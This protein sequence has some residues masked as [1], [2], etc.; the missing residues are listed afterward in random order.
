MDVLAVAAMPPFN[1][2]TDVRPAKPHAPLLSDAAGADIGRAHVDAMR[3]RVAAMPF[4][5]EVPTPQQ[6]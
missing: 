1:S 6:P 5:T 3:A 2:T 4:S